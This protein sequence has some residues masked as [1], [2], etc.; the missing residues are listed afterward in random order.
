MML[1][2][3]FIGIL[4]LLSPGLAG[5]TQDP[6]KHRIL[7]EWT[8]S[9][10]FTEEISI[11]VDTI[12]S[13]NHRF[14]I[15]DKFSPVNAYPGNYGL[16]FYQINFFDRVQDP[17]MYLYKYYYPFMHLPSNAVFMDTQVPFTEVAWTYG[18]PRETSEQTFRVRHSQSISRYLNFGLIYDI[19]YSLGQYNYQR[20]EDKTFILHSS[21]TGPKYKL[22][23]AGGINNLISYENG[24]ITLKDQLPQF[25]PRD[26]LVNLGGEN[27]AVSN[28]KNKNLLLV[29]RYTLGKSSES[30]DS[31][32]TKKTGFFG[33][34]GTFSHILLLESN[35]RT[36][37]DSY[38]GSGFYDS[39][40]VNRSA[41]FDSLYFRSIKNTLRF[42][43]TT[44]ETRKFSLGGGAGI[45]NELFRYTQLFPVPEQPAV[46][47]AK[48]NRGNNVLVGKLYNNIG[49]KL[50]WIADGE[51]FF[52]GYRAG[53]FTVIGEILKSFDLK[54]GEA[55]WKIDG[56]MIN[57]Q[58]SFWLEHWGSNHFEWHNNLNKELRI[59]L[60]TTFS[61]PAG[62]AELK[63][64]YAIINNYTDFDTTAHPAQYNGALSVASLLVRKELQAWKFHLKSDVLVQKSTNPSILDLPFVSA[65]AAG[66]FEHMFRFKSTNGKLYTQLGFDV[67]YH[68]LYYPYAYMP[69]T[70][71]YYRQDRVKTGNYPFVD[72]FLN[73]KLLRTRI[74]IMFDHVN[75]GML[76]YDYFMI[77]NNPMNIRMLRYGIA[78]TFYN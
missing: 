23:F 78:W 1:R 10:D 75:S 3:T 61:Y 29:Q 47:F 53:D 36:Y 66:F 15:S 11:P 62:R 55:S 49:K 13:L 19:I 45:R 34:S 42:D 8:L 12:F 44:D 64:N 52:T 48:W 57:W 25:A 7:R 9:S 6:V 54:K 46:N 31:S 60:G 21:Y 73:L 39:I 59:D 38:P 18:A 65:R 5:Q 37:S 51:L 41:T 71:R 20:S 76:G 43:F 69:A 28:L 74:F 63:I 16:P 58:P 22:Y 17:D 35:K 26:V 50:K 32:V 67:R 56:R 70:G 40:L 68:T 4:I 2:C 30:K 33:L 77:P 72:I 24:G 27:K 14:R